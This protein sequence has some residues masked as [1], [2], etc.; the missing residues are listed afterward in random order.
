MCIQRADLRTSENLE[1]HVRPF[2]Q[3]ML[4]LCLDTSS[5]IKGSSVTELVLGVKDT[6]PERLHPEIPYQEYV[7]ACFE[8]Y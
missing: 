5:P 8:I 3:L 4:N 1:L 2:T 7:D 6:V